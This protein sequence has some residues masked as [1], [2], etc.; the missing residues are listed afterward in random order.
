MSVFSRLCLGHRSVGSMVICRFCCERKQKM[1]SNNSIYGTKLPL[2]NHVHK[3]LDNK[4]QIFLTFLHFFHILLLFSPSFLH[5]F[6]ITEGFFLSP[7]NKVFSVAPLYRLLRFAHG[8]VF[9]PQNFF[10]GWGRLTACIAGHAIQRKNPRD[11][12]QRFSKWRYLLSPRCSVVPRVSM[13][14]ARNRFW[15]PIRGSCCSLQQPT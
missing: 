10:I 15:V 5:F 7:F 14:T 6:Q 8:F 12:S 3:F 4:I 1:L 2:F 11:E 13:C 9:A